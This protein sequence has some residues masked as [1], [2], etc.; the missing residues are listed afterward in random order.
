MKPTKKPMTV[1]PTEEQKEVINKAATESGLG[2]SAYCVQAAYK[3]AKKDNK[4]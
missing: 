1:Y 4:Q 2:F 3:Q